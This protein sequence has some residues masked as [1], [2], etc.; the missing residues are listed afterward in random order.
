MSKSFKTA[1]TP[2][3]QPTSDQIVAFVTKGQQAEAAAVAAGA[4]EP[5]ARLSLDVPEALHSRFKAACA[6]HRLKMTG[7]LL[8][9]M[10]RRAAELEKGS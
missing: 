3:R 6:R 1:P 5:S 7:E 9:F 10:E 4:K 2:T 8:A